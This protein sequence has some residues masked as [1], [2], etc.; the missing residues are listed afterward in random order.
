M[1]DYQTALTRSELNVGVLQTWL[2]RSVLENFEPN[3]YFYQAGVKPSIPGGYNTVGWAKFTQISEDSVT[4]GSDSTDG[5]SPASIDF[6]ATVITCTPIQYRVVVSLSDM[7]I[8]LNVLNFLQG[9]AVEV[10]AAMARKIDKVIQTTIMAGTY[11]IYGGA[12]TSRSALAATDIL[13]AAK[14]N[15]ASTL[16]QARYAP[17]IGGFY[18]AYAHPYQ[19]YDLRS[20]TGAGNWLEVN[21]YVTPD[22]IFRG[23]IGALNGVRVIMNAFIQKF[24]STVDV[25]PCLVTGANAY[26]VS[27]FQSLKT[28]VTPA[29]ASDSDPLQQRRKV[30]AKVAFAAIRLQEASMLRIETGVTALE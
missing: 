28:Y 1:S 23:E 22:K 2:N 16:L 10:G 19:I 30:G 13:T 18:V 24:S 20:E 17:T 6:D 29:V 5:V 7:L 25:Y 15:A 21:K 26:G 3:L 9:A 12:K 4:T 11:V 8:D 14:L 27:D